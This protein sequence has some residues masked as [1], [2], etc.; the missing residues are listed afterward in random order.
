MD[1]F[2]VWHLLMIVTIAATYVPCAKILART[3]RSRWWAILAL[4]P[5]V[6]IAALWVF[7]FTRWPALDENSD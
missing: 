6:N 1:T 5:W 4:I 7:A 3:G 2:S